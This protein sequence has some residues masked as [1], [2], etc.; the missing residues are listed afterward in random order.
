MGPASR[1][2]RKNAVEASGARTRGF[3]YQVPEKPSL[4]LSGDFPRAIVDPAPPQPSPVRV[5]PSNWPRPHGSRRLRPRRSCRPTAGRS[6]VKGGQGAIRQAGAKL[7]FLPKY[8]PDLN[9]IEQV[10]SKLKHLLRK[11][12]AR[13]CDAILSAIDRLLKTYPPEECSNYFQ[14]SGYGVV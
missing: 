2:R 7:L 3:R 1:L 8:S 12:Q 9:P 14:N 13:S 10:F 4:W 11:A 5:G 6:A